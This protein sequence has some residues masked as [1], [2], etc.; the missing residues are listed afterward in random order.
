MPSGRR[1]I[2][3]TVAVVGLALGAA[4]SNTTGLPAPTVSN[5]V[6]TSTLYALFGTP[7]TAPSAYDLNSRFLLHQL[8]RTDQ[9]SSF[10]FAFNFDSLR[11]PVL[12]PTGALGL[13]QSSGLQASSLAFT[14]VT[15]APSDGWVLDKPLVVSPGSVATVRSRPTN[16]LFGVTVY[17]Y[18]KLQV[19][20]VDTTARTITFQILVDQDCGYHSLEPGTPSQ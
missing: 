8:V 19:L 11:R 13:G 20:T 17:L 16:C 3:L 4:C 10:D 1:F 5:V 6:D 14:A 9:S 18:A 12:L 15:T 2:T 7:I